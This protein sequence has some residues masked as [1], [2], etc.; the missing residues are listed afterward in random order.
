M[1]IYVYKLTPHI[2]KVVN[3]CKYKELLYLNHPQVETMR[4]KCTSI[5]VL[6]MIREP[7]S[8]GAFKKRGRTK[9][10]LWRHFI[11]PLVLKSQVG[12]NTKNALL[13]WMR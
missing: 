10:E 1:R 2:L 13:Q 6:A 4:R 8:C 12:L 5:I 9:F 3:V 7:P 11:Q